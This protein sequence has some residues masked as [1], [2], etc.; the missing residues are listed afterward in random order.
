M[1]FRSKS[2]VA[3]ARANPGKLNYASFGPGSVAHV[4][5]IRLNK[6]LGLDMI[7]VPYKGAGPLTSDLVAGQ[8][9][10]AVMSPPAVCP[11]GRKA[12]VAAQ[13]PKAARNDHTQGFADT[14]RI[15]ATTRLNGGAP[16]GR[17]A[18]ALRAR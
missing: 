10:F 7:H 2:F 4:G 13:T 12:T 15:V 11:V 16:H 14:P 17:G 6:E 18:R 8:V 5:G 9:E 1:L 3:Y